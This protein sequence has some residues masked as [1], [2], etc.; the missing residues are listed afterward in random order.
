MQLSCLLLFPNRLFRYTEATS[1]HHHNS[2]LLNL[3]CCESKRFSADVGPKTST[4][5]PN[6]NSQKKL[7]SLWE[8]RK[9]MRDWATN[10]T[11]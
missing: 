9:S 5:P 6:R 11:L 4:V 3:S 2:P 8:S 10:F 1:H 7:T